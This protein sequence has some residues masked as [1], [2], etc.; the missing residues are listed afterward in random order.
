[1]CFGIIG[2]WALKPCPRALTPFAPLDN[3]GLTGCC[4]ATTGLPVQP[5][6]NA[7]ET[8]CMTTGYI[9]FSTTPGQP[10][11]APRRCL[12]AHEDA[13]ASP[14]PVNCDFPSDVGRLTTPKTARRPVGAAGAQLPYKQ[15]VTSS[16]L[17]P[18]TRNNGTLD[19]SRVL[20]SPFGSYKSVQHHAL[21]ATILARLVSARY[22]LFARQLD[23]VFRARGAGAAGPM[24]LLARFRNVHGLN[25]VLDNVC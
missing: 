21:G 25:R 10:A 12:P 7:S 9:C 11:E 24:E 5:T 14:L 13:I 15:K 19:C 6:R 22:R 16:N 23:E 18:A 3:D 17:V 4:I 8:P 2:R 20:S 1:M